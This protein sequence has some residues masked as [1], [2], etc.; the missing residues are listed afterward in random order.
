MGVQVL[1]LADIALVGVG[2]WMGGGWEEMGG[3]DGVGG[4]GEVGGWGMDG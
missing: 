2:V 1:V 4:M 3:V